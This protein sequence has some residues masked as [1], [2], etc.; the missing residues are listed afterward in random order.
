MNKV[1]TYT[2]SC[3]MAPLENMEVFDHRSFPLSPVSTYPSRSHSP[4]LLLD[5]FTPPRPLLLLLLL[6][7]LHHSL[8]PTFAASILTSRC[9]PDIFDPRASIP[10]PL[11]RSTYPVPSNSSASRCSSFTTTSSTSCCSPS[12]FLPSSSPP[13]TRAP[14][15][16]SHPIHTTPVNSPSSHMSSRLPTQLLTIWTW[17]PITST[18]LSTMPYSSPARRALWAT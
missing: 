10:I 12:Y 15:P 13:R 11:L 9:N 8:S 4:I 7:F 3:H 2:Q 1:L 5:L 16:P 14:F 18:R 17:S 6:L